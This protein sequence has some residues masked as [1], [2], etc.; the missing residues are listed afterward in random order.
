MRAGNGLARIFGWRLTMPRN[1][2][3]GTALAIAALSSFV[4]VAHDPTHGVDT[5]RIDAT[6]DATRTTVTTRVAES[7]A[8]NRIALQNGLKSI[9][10]HSVLHS[11]LRSELMSPMQRAVSLEGVDWQAALAPET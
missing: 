4:A 10:L 6:L 5:S 7:A 8:S 3:T 11:M 1:T 9:G 2:R